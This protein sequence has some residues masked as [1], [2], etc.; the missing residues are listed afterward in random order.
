MGFDFP[1]KQLQL[2]FPAQLCFAHCLSLPQLGSVG[3]LGSRQTEGMSLGLEGAVALELFSG[4]SGNSVGK[5]AGAGLVALAETSRLLQ[6]ASSIPVPARR[7]LFPKLLQL[8]MQN[9]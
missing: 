2:E 3:L 9:K 5:G 7:V 6:R 4:N 1:G 8:E